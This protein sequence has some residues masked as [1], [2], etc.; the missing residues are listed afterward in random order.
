MHT[1]TS[2]LNFEER[3]KMVKRKTRG[4]T[5]TV[6]PLKSPCLDLVF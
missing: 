1:G 3:V 5:D 6:C 2:A 4:L